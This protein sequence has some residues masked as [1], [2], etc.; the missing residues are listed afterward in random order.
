[1]SPPVHCQFATLKGDSSYVSSLAI[2][3]D[4]LYVA[5]SDGHIRLS[6]L[7][8]AMDDVQRPEQ[9]SFMVT[10]ANSPINCIIS[11]TRHDLVITSHQVGETRV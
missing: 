4:S 3:G 9:S 11:T 8:I 10:V 7:D 6:P 2:D 1:M 5:S